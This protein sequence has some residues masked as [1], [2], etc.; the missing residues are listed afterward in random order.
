MLLSAKIQFLLFAIFAIGICPALAQTKMIRS[1]DKTLKAVIIPVGKKGF[2]ETESRVEIC[3][4]D[5]MLLRWRSFA[6]NDGEHGFGVVHGE[7]TADSQFFVFNVSSSGGHMP[8]NTAIYFYSRVNGKF[9]HLDKY[10]GPVTSDFEL[11]GQHTLKTTRYNFKE[12]QEKE[13]VRVRL[14][15]LQLGKNDN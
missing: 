12:N 9:Y 15:K 10:I 14:R 4:V 8:W 7:W 11:E 2:V 1:P 3:N 6:S 13:P 5:G